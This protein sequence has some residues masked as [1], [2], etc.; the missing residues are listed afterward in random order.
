MVR[1]TLQFSL[2]RIISS[3]LFV[4]YI[5]SFWCSTHVCGTFVF[6][7][8]LQWE[9]L[10]RR[11]VSE[12]G[13]DKPPRR[14]QNTTALWISL[15]ASMLFTAHKQTISLILTPKR[16]P[17]QKKNKQKN[18]KKQTPKPPQKTKQKPQPQTNQ[19]HTQKSSLAIMFG[20]KT[21]A[22][23]LSENCLP[24]GSPNSH[25]IK[26]KA[27]S[28]TCYKAKR[29]CYYPLCLFNLQMIYFIV[30]KTT[31]SY[32]LY[33]HQGCCS[34]VDHRGRDQYL[35]RIHHLLCIGLYGLRSWCA[36]RQGRLF[37]YVIHVRHLQCIVSFPIVFQSTLN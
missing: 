30:S 29:V 20:N 31:K 17:P 22:L 10:Q 23:T 26:A 4:T 24:S 21:S 9:K 18:K 36:C 3:T 15:K 7:R 25:L 12:C 1:D 37:W 27:N 33:A 5:L 14:Y 32:M 8:G 6:K 19:K 13:V 35:R 16:T 28:R 11:D 34:G 2:P